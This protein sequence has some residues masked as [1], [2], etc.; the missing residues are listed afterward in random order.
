MFGVRFVAERAFQ[1]VANDLNEL[2]AEFDGL[3]VLLYSSFDVVDVGE[4]CVTGAV[5]GPAAEEV[6]VLAA[7]AS[8]GALLDQSSVYV[9]FEAAVAAPEAAFEVMRVDAASLVGDSAGV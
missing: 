3:V 9:A 2:G 4:R 6:P 5:L 7:V 8:D 1:V